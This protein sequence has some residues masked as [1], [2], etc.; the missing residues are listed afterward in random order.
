M[1]GAITEPC[2]KI[3]NVPIKRIVKIN[4][5]NQNFFLILR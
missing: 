2:V 4:G 3:I 1:K 5:A